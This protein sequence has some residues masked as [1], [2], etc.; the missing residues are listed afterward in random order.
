MLKCPN[1]GN[2]FFKAFRDC[3]QHI[4]VDRNEEV[5]EIISLDE[6]A[7][8]DDAYQCTECGECFYWDELND[9]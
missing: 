2:T 7:I 3:T 1:C 4:V 6:H 5:V 9:F 8:C